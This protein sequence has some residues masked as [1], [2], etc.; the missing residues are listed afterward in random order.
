M[1]FIED[2]TENPKL[3]DKFYDELCKAE[4]NEKDLCNFL[5]DKGYVGVSE[6]DCTTL[7][8]AVKA[9]LPLPKSFNLKY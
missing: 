2:V 9:Q 6:K 8:A 4:A 5:H 7:L 1:D 3:L